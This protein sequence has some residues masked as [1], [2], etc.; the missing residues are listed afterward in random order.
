MTS[1]WQTIISIW[2]V[3]CCSGLGNFQQLPPVGE[4]AMNEPDDSPGPLV[5]EKFQNVVILHESHHHIGLEDQD[6]DQ[7]FQQVFLA[8]CETGS[9]VEAEDWYVL[10]TLHSKCSICI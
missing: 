1:I 5:Y 6:Q 9:L 2:Q 8:Q 10:K 3:Y 7:A 4:T